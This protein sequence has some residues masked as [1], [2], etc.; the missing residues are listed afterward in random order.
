M[1]VVWALAF[2]AVVVGGILGGVKVVALEQEPPTRLVIQP[3]VQARLNVLAAGMVSEIGLCLIG[4]TSADTAYVSH[5]YMPT[6]FQ[7]TATRSSAGMCPNNTLA[8]AHNH[9]SMW[10]SVSVPCLLSLD[11][12]GLCS[13]AKVHIV[14]N[15]TN[16]CVL[17]TTDRTTAS[18]SVYPFFVVFVT[19]TIS[20]WWTQAQAEADTLQNA[21]PL[22][23]QASWLPSSP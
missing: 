9:P 1:R 8:Y 5:V 14:Y 21:L 13:G 10:V 4:Y 17:S 22:P 19:P 15:P 18:K 16:L 11:R 23:G 2:L 12:T 6:P 20:C 7:S 3:D